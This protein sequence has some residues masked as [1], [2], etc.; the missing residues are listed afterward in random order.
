[1]GERE[2]EGSRVGRENCCWDVIYERRIHL[3]GEEGREGGRRR[4][5]GRGG[6]SGGRGG[7]GGDGGG[8][9][10]GASEGGRQ[11]GNIAFQTQED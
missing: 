1:V 6:R 4:K 10:G 11:Q 2:A 5:G 9:G 3:K 8:G 7:R